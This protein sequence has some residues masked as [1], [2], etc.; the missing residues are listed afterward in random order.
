MEIIYHGHSCIQLSAGG[1]SLVIDP[2]ISGNPL[3]KTTP[4]DIKVDY[5]L[6]T[7]AHQDHILDAYPVAKANDATIVATFELA[8]YMEFQGAKT[9]PMNIGGKVN[10]GFAEVQ[11][12][13]AFH[14]SG[15]VLSEQG[16]IIYGGMPAGFLIRWNGLTLY[17]SGDTGLFSDLKMF[18]ELFDIDVAFLP[19]GDLFTMGPDDAVLAAEWL[20]AKSVVPLHFDTFPPIRQD[21]DAFAA[22]LESKGIKGIALKPG[23]RHIIE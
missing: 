21:V 20:R 16:Q 7:H 23:D 14:S 19:I 18:G 4:D 3:A 10:L 1:N 2:F 6:L 11:M 8:A 22:K 13:Q 15:I 12:T 17:H 9:Q 5:V